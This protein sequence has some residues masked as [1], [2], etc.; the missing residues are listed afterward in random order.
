[1]PFKEVMIG[2]KIKGN[3]EFIL[4]YITKFKTHRLETVEWYTRRIRGDFIDYEIKT[5]MNYNE[6]IN[7]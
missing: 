5:I 6:R 3:P 2:K 1:M 4:M 7:R